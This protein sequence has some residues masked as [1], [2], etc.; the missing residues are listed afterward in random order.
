MSAKILKPSHLNGIFPLDS[1]MQCGQDENNMQ[2]LVM[3]LHKSGDVFRRIAY[4]EYVSWGGRRN[5]SRFSELA[6]YCESEEAI[7]LFSPAYK[8]VHNKLQLI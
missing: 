7:I 6:K 2:W 5:E 8:S 1:V 3:Q 4:D